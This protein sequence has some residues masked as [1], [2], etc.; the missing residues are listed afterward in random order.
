MRRPRPPHKKLH[1]LFLMSVL[2]LL[3]KRNY[4]CS[5]LLHLGFRNVPNH[6]LH[7]NNLHQRE[8]HPKT[9][10]FSTLNERYV[11][12]RSPNRFHYHLV[13]GYLTYMGSTVLTA[14]TSHK[15]Q[16]RSAS[17]RNGGARNTTSSNKDVMQR[18]LFALNL[19]KDAFGSSYAKT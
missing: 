15:V 14:S 13:L 11:V 4:Q 3:S 6:R 18:Y 17:G 7:P 5:S 8:Q 2:S 16:G 1:N 12:Q 10:P 19:F 9:T